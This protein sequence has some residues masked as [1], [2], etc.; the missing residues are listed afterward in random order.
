MA[1]SQTKHTVEFS[2]N[3]HTPSRQPALKPATLR[4]ETTVAPARGNFS[5]LAAPTPRTKTGNPHRHTL[6]ATPCKRQ[7]LQPSGPDLP[8]QNQENHT[9]HTQ[10]NH[11]EPRPGTSQPEPR[12]PAA[13][14]KLHPPQ[15]N[16]KS[17][18][19]TPQN[20]HDTRGRWSNGQG[21]DGHSGSQGVD[22]HRGSTVN[23]RW[24][25]ARSPRPASGCLSRN[26]GNRGRCGRPRTPR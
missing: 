15:H 12:S 3:T 24:A 18:A 4:G 13:H 21:V 11:P 20:P 6:Q 25:P 5:S 22:A 1:L 2:N 9:H 17:P 7:L 14:T 19:H 10:S 23:G 26:R 16:T 8:S